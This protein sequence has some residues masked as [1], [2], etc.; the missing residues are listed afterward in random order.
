MKTR[1][2]LAAVVALAAAAAPAHGAATITIVNADGAGEGFND[3]TAAAPV[4]GNTGATVGAQRLIAFQHA[5]DIWGATLD[6][7]AEI[8]VLA[9]FDPLSCT[10]TSAVL[11][12]AGATFVFADFPGAELANVWYHSALADKLAQGDLNPGFADLRARFNANLGQPTCL[13]SSG[14]YYGLDANEP[15]GRIDLVAVLLHEFA[16]GLGFSGFHS[17]TTGAPLAGRGS[18]Y[19]HYVYDVTAAKTWN[20]M[21][22][23]QVAASAINSRK[24]VWNGLHANV[25][26]QSTLTPGTPLLVVS[27][28]A[29]VAGA[30]EI[31][32]ASFGPAFTAS[33]VSGELVLALDDTNASGPSTT[34]A[35]TAITNAAA[36]AGKVALVDRGT[37]GF[38][39]KVK[40][41]Q[42]AGAIAVVVADNVAGGP[43]AGLGGADPTITIPSGR[44]T[45][46]DGNALRANLPAQVTLKV[47][48]NVLAGTEASTGL[49]H[50]NAP[51]PVQPGSSISHWDPIAFRNQLMEPAINSDLTHTVVAP[52][53]LTTAQFTDIGWFS[54]YDGV[55]DGADVCLGSDQS[56]TVVI[57]G[58]DSGA[59]N[60]VFA[61]GCRISDEI[62]EIA[63]G[64]RNHGQFVSGVSHYTNRLK[65]QG[66]ITE[67]QKGAIQSCA[68]QSNLP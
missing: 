29:A 51:N 12:S 54:D 5:A 57:D 17:V 42:N 67:A 9:S 2:L 31:G 30:R 14:W 7:D 15:A 21:T 24:V 26:A 22:Q 28:P 55:P 49:L 33:G 16:H 23:P 10:A 63:A 40:N 20:Q 59:P 38:V 37:C 11:G 46:A 52:V 19:G 45:L 6:S 13:A 39:V 53:D 8:F 66:V 62:E 4:G 50:L 43:P 27:S 41:A 68:G 60:V 18:V 65:K 32:M 25:D 48:P 36:V 61:D 64:A 47:D 35:C 58:C 44:V 34:D 56:A 1:L 3:P